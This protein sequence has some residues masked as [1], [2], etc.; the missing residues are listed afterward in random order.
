ML[1]R[2]Y[3]ANMWNW[4]DS[5]IPVEYS[6]QIA[7]KK[8]AYIVPKLVA[9]GL[10]YGAVGKYIGSHLTPAQ[11]QQVQAAAGVVAAGALE[12][13]HDFLKLKYPQFKWL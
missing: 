9:A 8:V 7:A 2:G 4:V 1:R 13:L 10:A 6:F 11:L 3:G 5:L 12:G